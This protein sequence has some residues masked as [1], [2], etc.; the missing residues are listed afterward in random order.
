MRIGVT[1]I[2]TFGP[3]ALPRSFFVIGRKL[4]S[5]GVVKAR[6]QLANRLIGAIRPGTVCQ[7]GDSDAGVQ[8]DPEGCASE[9]KMT[10]GA[11]RKEV[12]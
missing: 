9:P 1:A 6:T 10:D 3:A 2:V 5:D 11:P 7:Q 8:I 12:S 4:P